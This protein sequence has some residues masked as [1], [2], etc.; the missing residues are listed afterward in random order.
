MAEAWQKMVETA[1]NKPDDYVELGQKARQ[2]TLDNFTL[3]QQVKQHEDL[4]FS[5]YD[6]HI[7]SKASLSQA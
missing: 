2:R 4:Y 5:L 1:Q 7:A 3:E 6:K